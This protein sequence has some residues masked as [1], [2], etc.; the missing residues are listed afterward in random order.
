MSKNPLLIKTL[1]FSSV[2]LIWGSTWLAMAIAVT[3][4]PPIFATGLRFLFASPVLFLL[5]LFYKQ[6][7]YKKGQYKWM[8]LISIFYF[9]IPF[10]FMIYGEMYIS[11]GLAAIIF[12]TM[13]I[14]II[15]V[16]LVTN[17]VHISYKEMVG[18][19]ISVI[20]LIC[21]I[22]NEMNVGGESY[23]LGIFFI[24]TA[25]IVHAIMYVQVSK[26][27]K[28]AILTYNTLPCFVASLILLSI[29]F[30]FEDV[31]YN[32][33]ST[34]SMYSVLFLGLIA[35]VGGVI[36]Y[37]KLNEISNPFTASLCFIFFPLVALSLSAI[38][39]KKELQTESLLF[40]GLLL[41][42]IIIAKYPK[43]IARLK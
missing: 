18:V 6:P 36:A 22:S 23:L 26:K 42:G 33:I 25:V 2:C 14:F 12:S 5:A 8:C 35:S 41:F 19:F 24:A 7:L 28:M 16:C 9:S 27:C 31:N 32:A 15:I 30:A 37:F 4:I 3:T 29:S 10:T 11:S 21:I 38:I 39:E 1:L 34:T 17:T 13:P 40:M 43:K 20:A